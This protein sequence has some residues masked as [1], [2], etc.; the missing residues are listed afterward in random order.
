MVTHNI[1]QGRKPRKQGETYC[2][3]KIPAPFHAYASRLG[4]IYSAQLCC[5]FCSLPP[6]QDALFEFYI[7]VLHSPRQTPRQPRQ[8]SSG[9]LFTLWRVVSPG[10]QRLRCCCKTK[11]PHRQYRRHCTSLPSSK[12]N[13]TPGINI[14]RKFL[15]PPQTPT[16]SPASNS[17]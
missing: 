2:V 8:V 6:S 9:R 14:Y 17:H 13:S 16:A 3:R 4:C 12:R 15:R 1:L 5:P 7:V 10:F 11:N